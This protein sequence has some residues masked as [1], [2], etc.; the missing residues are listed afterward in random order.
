M[1]RKPTTPQS[2]TP[3]T[4]VERVLAAMITTVL[5]LTLVCFAALL[6]AAALGVTGDEWGTG[7]WPTVAVIPLISL[8]LGFIGVIVLIVVN[9]RRRRNASRG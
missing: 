6:I 2:D 9:A 7:I 4:T 1:A 3:A 8:P 5:G